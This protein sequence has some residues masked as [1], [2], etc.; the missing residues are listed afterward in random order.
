[1]PA[2]RWDLQV[3]R[4]LWALSKH[5]P[6]EAV[7]LLQQALENC[8]PSRTQE[9]H[10]ICFYLG[11][12]LRRL[13]FSQSAIKSWISCQR[14]NKRGHTRKMLLRL[15]NGYGMER[16][17]TVE[18][19]DWQAFYSIQAARYLLNKN[20]RTFSVEAEKDMIGD[21]IRDSWNQ[22]QASEALTDKSSCE[23]LE[24]FRSV[25]IVFPTTVAAEPK[26]GES[27]IAVN[28][29]TRRK[30][31]LTDRCICGSGLPFVQCCG[32]TPGKEEL[33]SGIF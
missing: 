7:Q 19:D 3:K 26:A 12:A 18:G 14:L 31:A 16:Q 28:F 17:D 5:H 29:R 23:K 24:V 15:T 22:L 25:V 9:L 33:L 6:S 32:R 11:I 27:V 10:R 13:G 2:I 20:K 30:V 8:P 1:M 4:G 21:L